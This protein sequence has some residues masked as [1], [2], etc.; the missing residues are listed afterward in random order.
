MQHLNKLQLETLIGKCFTLQ[1]GLMQAA[2]AAAAQLST[3]FAYENLTVLKARENTLGRS[4]TTLRAEKH[5]LCIV[6]LPEKADYS[7]SGDNGRG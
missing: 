7:F 3:G 1:Y 5:F 4:C 6:R 2:A